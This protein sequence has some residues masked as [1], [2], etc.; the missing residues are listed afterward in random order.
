MGLLNYQIKNSILFNKDNVSRNLT[1]LKKNILRK[2]FFKLK[3]K[4]MFGG[5]NLEQVKI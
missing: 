2:K 4:I 3:K 1:T 5:T